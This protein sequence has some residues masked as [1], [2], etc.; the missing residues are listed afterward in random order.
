VI[1]VLVYAAAMSIA[2][3][4]HLDR[5]HFSSDFASARVAAWLW[6]AVYAAVV[7]IGIPLVFRQPVPERDPAPIIAPTWLNAL[8]VA[9]GAVLLGAGLWL[10]LRPGVADWWPWQPVTPL[11]G[12][13]MAAWLVPIGLAALAAVKERDLRRAAI[14]AWSFA[15]FAILQFVALLRFGD[16]V[17]WRS[18][19]GWIYSALL[20]TILIAGVSGVLL[21]WT[22][23]PNVTA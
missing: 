18:G 8:L 16:Q 3:I 13:A 7:L 10:A 15:A 19:A 21:S 5:F 11:A 6:V 20:T 4:L 22:R 9:Q 14:L 23:P 12:R 2:T 1:T 17:N